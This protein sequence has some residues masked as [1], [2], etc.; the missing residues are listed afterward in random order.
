MPG[1]SDVIPFWVLQWFFGWDVQ[2]TGPEGIALRDGVCR[3]RAFEGLGL[4]E[5]GV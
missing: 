1:P 5:F 2:Y 3:F 4:M